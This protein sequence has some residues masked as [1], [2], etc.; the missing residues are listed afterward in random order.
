MVTL[1]GVVATVLAELRGAQDSKNQL[2]RARWLPNT[3]RRRAFR[4]CPSQVRVS[5]RDGN[6]TDRDHPPKE[7][8]SAINVQCPAKSSTRF[9]LTCGP[10]FD[11]HCSEDAAMSHSLF[12]V[13]VAVRRVEKRQGGRFSTDGQG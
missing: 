1:E 4:I 6:Q 5:L 8:T 9:D 12:S 11:H 3:R 13:R 7:A 10:V 2:T